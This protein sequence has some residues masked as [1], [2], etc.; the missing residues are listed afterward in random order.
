[1]E[2]LGNETETIT[3]Q[4]QICGLPVNLP[5]G[6]TGARDM[7]ER[8][9]GLA[10]MVIHDSC[11]NGRLKKQKQTEETDRLMQRGMDFRLL[12]P[13]QYLDS[14][15]WIE[16]PAA[17]K[18]RHQAIKK[19]LAW[20][21]GPMGLIMH[22][23][24]SGTGKTTT[25][26]LICEREFMA[27]RLI[28]A[29]THKELADKA[30]WMAKELTLETKRWAETLRSCDLL[31]IDDLGKSRFKSVTGEG[32]ASEEFL[33]DV[34]D[35]RI[36]NKVPTIITVNMTGTETAKAMSGDKG[37]YFIRRMREFFL[38]IPFDGESDKH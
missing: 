36:K 16:T 10:R 12:C 18:L 7:D 11:W 23:K 17:N 1:M 26:W 37:A 24:T 8:M 28:V 38:S 4:C 29:M 27:G 30:T 2:A 13:P 9:M 6:T 22:G 14:K 21:Y 33:F 35:D 19:S 5:W 31:F 3:I 32:R 20:Q 34:V 25:A 15:V